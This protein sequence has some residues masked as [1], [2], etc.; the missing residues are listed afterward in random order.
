LNIKVAFLFDINKGFLEPQEGWLMGKEPWDGSPASS[1]A[2]G[3]IIYMAS[4][5]S[6]RTKETT[7]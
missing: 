4:F 6:E 2:D 1:E 5:R 3:F 7:Q